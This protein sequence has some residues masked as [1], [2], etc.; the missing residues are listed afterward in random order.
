MI[1]FNL[2]VLLAERGI[3]INKV[4]KDTGLSRITL[5]SISNNNGQGIQLDTINKL[6]Q[7]L[8]ITPGELFLYVPFDITFFVGDNEVE[9]E[10]IHNNKKNS[11]AFG[12]EFDVD[13]IEHRDKYG[14]I[15]DLEP[16]SVTVNTWAFDEYNEVEEEEKEAKKEVKKY[17]NMLPVQLYNQ[18]ENEIYHKLNERALDKI[19]IAEPL[20]NLLSV[21]NN[22][23]LDTIFENKI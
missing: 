20:I 1:K 9:I 13:Y 18:L 15:E 4:H 7:Y 19:E 5:S 21:N 17:L 3:N 16:Y 2:S 6:C 11:Y 14:E 23:S 12:V 10:V 8:K 22:F